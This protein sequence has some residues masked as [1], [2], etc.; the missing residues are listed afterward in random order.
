MCFCHCCKHLAQIC[1]CAPLFSGVSWTFISLASA[2]SKCICYTVNM[3]LIA[4]IA[5]LKLETIVCW[6]LSSIEELGDS[7]TLILEGILSG[8]SYSSLIGATD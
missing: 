2:L 4:V 8:Q 5:K 6:H 3:A 1:Q 7:Q